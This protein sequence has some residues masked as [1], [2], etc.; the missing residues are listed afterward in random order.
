MKDS[1]KL[2]NYWL[3]Y[4]DRRYIVSWGRIFVKHRGVEQ[5]KNSSWNMKTQ[6]TCSSRKMC[7]SDPYCKRTY[8]SDTF[9]GCQFTRFILP[10][11][12]RFLPSKRLLPTFLQ[13]SSLLHVNAQTL[14]LYTIARYCLVPPSPPSTK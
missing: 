8:I 3:E 7:I 11:C 5:T 6:S 14:A 2:E 9:L 4:T 10:W 1:G 13:L 12:I